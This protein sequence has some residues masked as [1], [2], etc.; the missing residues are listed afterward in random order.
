M[1]NKVILLGNVGKDAEK[2]SDKVTRFSVA[3]TESWK[4][5]DGNYQNKTEWHRVVVYGNLAPIMADRCKKGK[6]VYVEGKLVTNEWE[7]NGE[8]RYTTE[9]IVDING[10][11]DVLGKREGSNNSSETRSESS[12][13][14]NEQPAHVKE[15]P[16]TPVKSAGP[17]R[18]PEPT[19]DVYPD[20]DDDIPF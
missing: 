11:I 13:S 7:K 6:E 12:Q 4:D 14:R 3:T 9:V 5:K 15:E 8:K 16:V 10:R 18:S 20:S 17:D 1:V 19:P 2:I